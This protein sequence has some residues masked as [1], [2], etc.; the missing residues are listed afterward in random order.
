MSRCKCAGTGLH[1]Q[2]CCAALKV[3][4]PTSHWTHAVSQSRPAC[5]RPGAAEAFRAAASAR[6]ASVRC[7]PLAALS[8]SCLL[9]AFACTW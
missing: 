4:R 5:R 6:R 1:K 9:A 8:Q 7:Q 2:G 3:R